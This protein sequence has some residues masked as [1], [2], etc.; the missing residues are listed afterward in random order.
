M[1]T[2]AAGTGAAE[3]AML[4][5]RLGHALAAPPGTKG[6]GAGVAVDVVPVAPEGASKSVPRVATSG[7]PLTEDPPRGIPGRAAPGHTPPPA[8]TTPGPD[9]RSGN[10]AVEELAAAAVGARRRGANDPA[11]RR[12]A[13]RTSA[14]ERE[15][16]GLGGQDAT[17]TAFYLTGAAHTAHAGPPRQGDLREGVWAEKDYDPV[18]N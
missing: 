9:G 3:P 4:P 1:A 2:D 10:A 8:E 16:Q 15:S 11:G 17:V 12:V 14:A 13:A 18:V 6:P 7:A 5:P